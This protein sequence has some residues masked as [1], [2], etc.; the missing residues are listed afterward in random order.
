MIALFDNVFRLVAA[1]AFWKV[2]RWLAGSRLSS[3]LVRLSAYSF[4]LFC[5]HTL[6]IRALGPLEKRLVGVMGDPYWPAFFLVQPVVALALAVMTGKGLSL[7]FP[8]PLRV[9]QRGR[10]TNERRPTERKSQRRKSS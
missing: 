6:V 1:I 10:P 3:W 4:L 5:S 9:L 8:H 7:V 2:A